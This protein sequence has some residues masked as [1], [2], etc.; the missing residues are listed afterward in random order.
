MKQGYLI[1][2]LIFAIRAQQHERIVG[3]TINNHDQE[4]M[5]IIKRPTDVQKKELVAG[6]YSLYKDW[7][8]AEIAEEPGNDS[9]ILASFAKDESFYV[10]LDFK[11][12]I[13]K[14]LN[15]K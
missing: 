12:E 2:F 9:F 5:Q 10:A 13:R 4:T 3:N 8:Y 11:S 7:R 15:K 1:I 14:L 6:Y